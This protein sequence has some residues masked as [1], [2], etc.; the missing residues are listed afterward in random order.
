MQANVI[1]TSV[2]PPDAVAPTSAVAPADASE[3]EATP[4]GVTHAPVTPNGQ[5]IVQ[6]RSNAATGDPVAVMLPAQSGA[7]L[8]PDTGRLTF[9]RTGLA[10][11]PALL[12]E[13]GS[14]QP[15]ALNNGSPV[16][17]ASA[18]VAGGASLGTAVDAVL[19]GGRA[20][21]FA[22]GVL[23]G[24]LVV[25]LTGGILAAMAQPAGENPHWEHLMFGGFDR[26]FGGL[27]STVSDKGG[28]TA[29]IDQYQRLFDGLRAQG[30][31][32]E[33]G[34]VFDSFVTK[35]G[36]A[37]FG[38]WSDAIKDVGRQQLA[39]ESEQRSAQTPAPTRTTPTPT[40]PAVQAPARQASPP[41]VDA[42]RDRQVTTFN[43]VMD[44][45][46]QAQVRLLGLAQQRQQ[47][48]NSLQSNFT[49]FYHQA[50]GGRSAAN[51]LASTLT[52]IDANIKK[53]Q[54]IYRD[55]N[56]PVSA[57]KA[58]SSR[59][60]QLV[61]TASPQDFSAELSGASAV[62]TASTN[63]DILRSSWSLENTQAQSWLSDRS[64]GAWNYVHQ[65][66]QTANAVVLPMLPFRPYNATQSV[67]NAFHMADARLQEITRNNLEQQAAATS[68][69]TPAAPSATVPP[70]QTAVTP[71]A[72][73]V[74]TA[75]AA[76][77]LTAATATP[78]AATTA[79]PASSSATATPDQVTAYW[80][81][82]TRTVSQQHT[83][84]SD[85]RLIAVD[86]LPGTGEPFD[87]WIN[88]TTNQV[89]FN[90]P[91][92]G[93]S[94]HMSGEI[95]RPEAGGSNPGGRAG[96]NI[97]DVYIGVR[98]MHV[99]PPPN[100][101]G[102]QR[103]NLA[104]ILLTLGSIGSALWFA[105]M[106]LDQVSSPQI[107]LSATRTTNA[108]L[109]AQTGPSTP[110][111]LATQRRNQIWSNYL[112]AAMAALRNV[113]QTGIYA[114]V[115]EALGHPVPRL[116][117][118]DLDR[119]QAAVD[120]FKAGLSS[121]PALSVSDRQLV[122]LQFQ[123][124]FTLSDKL[125]NEAVTTAFGLANSL[126]ATDTQSLAQRKFGDGTQATQ[127]PD[128]Q[129]LLNP[130][131][132]DLKAE[133]AKPAMQ[134]Y[135]GQVGAL[136]DSLNA[137]FPRANLN[138]DR[139]EGVVSARPGQPPALP[140]EF[141]RPSYANQPELARAD[142][143]KVANAFSTLQGLQ[144]QLITLSNELPSRVG[145]LP[146]SA[147]GPRA[148]LTHLQ[149]QVDT[150]LRQVQI[151][152]GEAGERLKALNTIVGQTPTTPEP[153]PTFDT[154]APRVTPPAVTPPDA[155]SGS[156]APANESNP[157]P[158]VPPAPSG[159][160]TAPPTTTPATPEGDA[161]QSSTQARD[162]LASIQLLSSLPLRA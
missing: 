159:I 88:P 56:E 83:S 70:A 35:L 7:D 55:A 107:D 99:Y 145:L 65:L 87:V 105:D 78:S 153:L 53:L 136:T 15:R 156:T 27:R 13:P 51:S 162:R 90:D 3:M 91:R 95:N 58:A 125:K 75:P 4:T 141:V 6:P 152:L 66:V 16:L 34:Q 48:W 122:S 108:A 96:R 26:F 147:V 124:P 72:P 45:A 94:V 82:I 64:S 28:D 49:K 79:A 158:T 98:N 19:A 102:P 76:P 85:M 104:S 69:Q 146:Q 135:V 17:V 106:Q 134:P 131:Q 38:T 5:A 32:S 123:P 41:T 42:A 18:A 8:N 74:P 40:A 46:R 10:Q 57:L 14:L 92:D 103:P 138:F 11:T 59:L 116:T 80:N 128:L 9:T 71:T 157:I 121:A 112:D 143:L 117:T 142:Q 2:Q 115:S 68:R 1:D 77:T 23:E 63:G 67:V 54:A 161:S 130:V 126:A 20:A 154:P 31:F 150:L 114:R 149:R 25:L 129:R 61:G 133:L 47:A 36:S 120:R 132:P 118:T 24:G 111:P 101:G 139:A 144:Q 60:Q 93:Q 52:D 140:P 155:P 62:A 37:A 151:A 30:R 86:R 100:G 73:N 50:A 22:L 97:G 39:R 160:P 127:T 21:S 43:A 148:A 113:H 137:T 33:A 12:T 84:D 44:S 119:L 89:S 110:V 109:I 81:P 29:A